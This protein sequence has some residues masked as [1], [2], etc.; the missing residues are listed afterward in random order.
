M[1]F[2]NNINMK[3]LFVALITPFDENNSIDYNSLNKLLEHVFNSYIT[4]IVILGSTGENCTL[5]N[6]EK[7][8][9]VEYIWHYKL[10]NKITKKIIVGIGGNNTKEC[11]N[12]GKEIQNYCDAFMITV[13][14]YN[15]PIQDAIYQHFKS[16]CSN[17]I[18]KDF[19]LYNIP[20]RTG[21]NMEPSCISK[22]YNNIKNI[23]AIKESSNSMSQICD[24]KSLCNINILAGDD[25]NLLTTNSL[26]GVGLVSVIGNLCPNKLCE[27][28]FC[29]NKEQQL[30]LFY[31]IYDLIKKIFL[32]SN[33]VPIKYLLKQ[34]NVIDSDNVRQPLITLSDVNKKLLEDTYELYIN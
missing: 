25:A 19:I 18:N 29:D 6:E 9:I 14:H 1:I 12:F 7:I 32:E 5:S 10:L 28:Y 8:K 15:K 34:I 31:K 16:I 11:I 17:F 13:P 33:P 3:G 26:G 20:S 23:V 30:K 4:G 27:M 22:C 2:Y 21:I 24:I